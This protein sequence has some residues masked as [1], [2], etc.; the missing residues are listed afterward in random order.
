MII[1]VDDTYNNQVMNY[2]KEEADFNLLIIGD[3]ERYGYNNYFLKIWADIDDYGNITGIL[4]K[5]FE[6]LTFYSNNK[7][8]TDEFCKLINTLHYVQISGKS[9]L[10]KEMAEKLHLKEDRIVNFCTLKND[11][12]LTLDTSSIKVKKIKFGNLKKVVKLYE[13]IDEFENTTVESIKNGLKSGRGYCIEADKKVVAMAKSTSENSTHAMIVGVATHP[14][15]R[16]K[17]F[18][19]TCIVKICKELIGE[20]KIPC[21]FYDNDEAGKIYHKLGFENRGTWSIYCK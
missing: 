12:K 1:K 6:Y 13:Y 18:A 19:T 17:G 20:N 16:N 8:N 4:L 10:I 2:L 15:Y 5:C 21:L 14:L 9:K 11:D 7:C 3:I